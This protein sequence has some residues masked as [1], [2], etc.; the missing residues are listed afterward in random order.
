M[1]IL[2]PKRQKKLAAFVVGWMNLLGWSIA[3]CSG[4]ST[5][6]A[7]V[8]GMMALWN[9]AFQATQWQMYVI[10]VVTAILSGKVY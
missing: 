2:A 5:V 6:V 7:S 8:S 3:L 4:L 10:Y 9:D 1:F